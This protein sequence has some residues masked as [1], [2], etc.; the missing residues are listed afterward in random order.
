MAET[1]KI[2]VRS[3]VELVTTLK[4]HN[5]ADAFIQ[6]MEA[7]GVFVAVSAETLDA[8]KSFFASKQL[9]QTSAFGR[10]IGLTFRTRGRQP[11]PGCEGDHCAHIHD[12]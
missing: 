1:I 5:Q 8:V 12:D 4:D 6:E 2:K 10:T 11:D 9:H 7:H 3:I